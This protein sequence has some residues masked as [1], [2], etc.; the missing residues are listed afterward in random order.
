MATDIV[1]PQ[2]GESIAEGTIVKWLVPLGAQVKK[3][4]SLLEVETDKVALDIPSPATGAL[5]EILIQEGE[6]VPVGTLLARL[7]YHSESGN[8][9]SPTSTIQSPVSSGHGQ[10]TISGSPE[11]LSPAVRDLAAKHQVDLSRITGTGMNGRITKK[12]ILEY[13][14]K[15]GLPGKESG[16]S[17][18]GQP[19]S[20]SPSL[21][22]EVIP[23]SSMRRTIAERMVKSRQT[24]AHV[25]TFF[26][27]DFTTIEPPRQKLHLTYLPFVIKAVTQGIN[28]FPILNSSWS[29]KGLILRHAV[30]IGIAVAVEEGLLVPVVKHAA[31]KDLRQLGKEVADLSQRARSKQLQPEE[32]QG[33]TFT[34][35]N[36][37]GT[38]SLF[39]TPIINQ[40]QIAILG[41]GAVQRRAVVVNESIEVRP[42]A[43]LS[44]AFDHRVIDGA[45]ADQFMLMVKSVLEQ[46]SWEVTS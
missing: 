28:A 41:V 8:G 26:E 4:E 45:T 21:D 2:L 40:P 25:V 10:S 22:E 34:I 9:D 16:D 13:L 1:M 14:D 23:L 31:Q 27:A 30:H 42:M 35:T 18:K 39:S 19:A 37:G 24:A 11:L 32:V 5:T 44:L 43:Y 6:T 15:Q 33:G 29:A 7:D 3:D 36:H 12:D 38:G 17:L 46:P 20:V